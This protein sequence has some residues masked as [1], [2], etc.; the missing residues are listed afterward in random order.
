MAP[1]FLIDIHEGFGTLLFL[2]GDY[3]QGK[4]YE[5]KAAVKEGDTVIDIGANISYFTILLANL[6]GPKGKVY[7]FELDPRNFDILQRTIKRN[8]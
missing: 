6:V 8:G 7:A 1:S 5:M 4:A 2:Q 3:S